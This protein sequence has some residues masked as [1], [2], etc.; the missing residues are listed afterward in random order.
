MKIKTKLSITFILLLIFGVTAVSSYSILFIRS[1]LLEEGKQRLARDADQLRIAV[2]YASPDSIDDIFDNFEDVS[3]YKL[4]IVRQADSTLFKGNRI[5]PSVEVSYF[6]G[7]VEVPV[8]HHRADEMLF[9]YVPFSTANQFRLIKVRQ[10]EDVLFEPIKVIRWI[11]YTGMFISIVLIVIVS[12]I[13]ARSISKPILELKEGAQR[14]AGGDVDYELHLNRK[15]EFGELTDSLNSMAHRLKEDTESLQEMY[16]RHRQFYADITHEVKNPLHTIRGALEMLEMEELPDQQRKN[17]ISV[18]QK[19]IDR[20]NRLFNDMLTLQRYDDDKT[21]ISKARF[22]LKDLMKRMENNYK[23]RTENIGITLEID[24]RGKVFC[25][26]ADEDKIEQVFDNLI[27]NAMRY[28]E[29]TEITL[30]ATERENRIDISVE[31]N[32][33]GIPEEHH[34]KVFDRFY[35]ADEARSRIKGGTGLGLAV[36]DSILRKHDVQ[37]QIESQVGKGTAFSFWLRKEKKKQA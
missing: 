14:I 23:Q 33:V 27:I 36:V 6:Q 21:M 15:D 24:L 22:N 8:Y 34:V 10:S 26:C 35:R 3:G 12:T 2:K 13:M 1:Y 31:D 17:Y 4:D 18:T 29:G 37:I 25:V 5:D 7:D 11:I 19:Q 28:S 9:A 20:L 16:D 30:K 32:G